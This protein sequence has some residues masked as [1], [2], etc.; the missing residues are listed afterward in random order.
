[1]RRSR[2]HFNTVSEQIDVEQGL[3]IR[4]QVCPACDSRDTGEVTSVVFSEVV[5][6]VCGELAVLKDFVFVRRAVFKCPV[7]VSGDW[8]LDASVCSL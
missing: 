1:M 5:G 8:C 7:Y 4:K 2:C 3:N 6:S